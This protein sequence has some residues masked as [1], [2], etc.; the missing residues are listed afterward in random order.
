[1]AW[2]G[3]AFIPHSFIPPP[4]FVSAFAVSLCLSFP[5][6]ICPTFRCR[7]NGTALTWLLPR[8][9][10]SQ[11]EK[12]GPL[13]VKGLRGHS[14]PRI[15]G[16]ELI[17]KPA[18]PETMTGFPFCSFDTVLNMCNDRENKI[19]I[20]QKS[21]FS[22]RSVLPCVLQ[23]GWHRW[24]SSAVVSYRVLGARPVLGE[25]SCNNSWL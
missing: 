7:L 23:W 24:Q 15:K 25:P 20:K 3:P 21:T 13:A 5:L 22:C 16:W 10:A 4:G 11:M 14:L 17:C 6:S 1:M 2:L 9:T 8:Q 18:K 12:G 19:C